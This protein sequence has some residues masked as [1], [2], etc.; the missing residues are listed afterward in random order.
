[1]EDLRQATVGDEAIQT[2]AANAN[3]PLDAST[4][5]PLG[6]K[7]SKASLRGLSRESSRLTSKNRENHSVDG[8]VI[9]ETCSKA[10]SGIP[11]A[12]VAT[13]AP[14]EL[15]DDDWANWDSPVSKSS[16]PRWSNGTTMS[17]KSTETGK[18]I[19]ARYDKHIHS[20]D[21]SVPIT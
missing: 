11:I 13:S 15:D 8:H 20:G 19:G 9:N 4:A 10:Q 12:A 17:S 14:S 7:T 3:V 21:D 6:K 2:T 18:S 1:M 16:S 5:N